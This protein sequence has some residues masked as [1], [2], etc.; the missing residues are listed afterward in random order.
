MDNEQTSNVGFE[1][2]DRDDARYFRPAIAWAVIGF[3]TGFIATY[4]TSR[5]VLLSLIVGFASAI[6]PGL[7]WYRLLTLDEPRRKNRYVDESRL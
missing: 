5:R 6:G 7:Y 1:R 3:F 4:L 2:A